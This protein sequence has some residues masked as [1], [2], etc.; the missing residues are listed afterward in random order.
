MSHD[1]GDNVAG[2]ESLTPTKNTLRALKADV[3]LESAIKELVDNALDGWKRHSDR[4][5][6]LSVEIFT[7]QDEESTEL[8]IRDNSG[9]V[10]RDEAAM[11]FGL[12]RSA[13]GDVP[14]SIG[15]YGLGAK[16][17]LVNLGVPFTITSRHDDARTGWAYTIDEAWFD[18]DEDWSVAVEASDEISSGTTEVRIHDLAYEWSDEQKAGLIADL[19]M[20]YNLFLDDT[21]DD[22]SY[23]IEI[24]VDGDV[25]EGAGLPDFSY[26]PFDEMHPRRYENIQIESEELDEPVEMH[27]TVGLLRKK[28]PQVAGTDIYCQKR[29]VATAARDNIGGFGK[30]R[31][32]LGA[33]TVHKERLKIIIELETD[34]DGQQLP[35]DTQKSAIDP[36]NKVMEGKNKVYNWVRRM[37]QPYYDL[38][39]N[40]V[41]E[42]FLEPYHHEKSQSQGNVPEQ[43]DYR[44]RANVVGQHKPDTSIPEINEMRDTVEAHATLG[45][46]CRRDIRNERFPAYQRQLERES[47]SEYAELPE[48]NVSPQGLDVA[49]VDEQLASI[50]E[51]AQ[52]HANASLRYSDDLHDW[53]K[54]AYE[55]K[56]EQAMPA[57]QSP[58]EVEP[59][60]E[61][62][63]T[64]EGLASEP[65]DAADESSAGPDGARDDADQLTLNLQLSEGEDSK[66]GVVISQSRSELCRKLG[67]SEDASFED[68]ISHLN[69]RVSLVLEMSA[70]AP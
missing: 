55:A 49:D 32:H 60:S 68:I 37:A 4:Y 8:V 43:F 15:T 13:K 20:T 14:G 57:G 46:R 50:E 41:P 52:A 33:F 2:K 34:G 26:S 40:K 62:P 31:D 58:E 39:A 22:E 44:S 69:Q 56:L 64:T 18:D 47:D 67:L 1:P 5:D 51:L 36:H 63:T 11:L 24:T 35:W 21:L 53:Q 9:G 61:I 19:G 28:D 12:G 3:T 59:P 23:D 65:A 45:F 16:K 42:A 66:E 27:V 10:P 70:P 29:K 7:D 30:G 17:A 6:H 54:F 48:L 38:D 25:V